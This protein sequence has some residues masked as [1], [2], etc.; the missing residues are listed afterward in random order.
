[1]T[2]SELKDFQDR[3]VILRLTDGETLRV[4]ISFVDMEYEDVIVDIIETD[5]P[6][7]YRT[8]GAAYTILASD[9]VSVTI[10]K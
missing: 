4:L 10:S 5:R 6:G 9:I 1:M 8:P 3:E 7:N 2:S